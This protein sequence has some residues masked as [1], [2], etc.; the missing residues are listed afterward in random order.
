MDGKNVSI[1]TPD[2]QKFVTRM[3][4]KLKNAI[5]SVGTT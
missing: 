1:T 4:E 3:T 2:G 5:K